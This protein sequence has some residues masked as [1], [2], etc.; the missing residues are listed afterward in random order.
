M[1]QFTLHFLT[2][3]LQKKWRHFFLQ[4]ERT[5]NVPFGLLA[6][7]LRLTCGYV[8]ACIPLS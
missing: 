3:N 4:I 5:L 7:T 6:A 2:F 1:T 8:V